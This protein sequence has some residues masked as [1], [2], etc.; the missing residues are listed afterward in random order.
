MSLFKSFFKKKEE[1]PAPEGMPITPEQKALVQETFVSV[2]VISEQAA[3][4]FYNKLFELDPSLKPMFKGDMKEQGRKLMAMLA[5][6]VKGLD[7]L[8]TLVPAVQDLGRRHLTY[9]VEDA[10]YDTVAAALLYTLETGLGKAW[11]PKVQDA[12]TTVYVVLADTMKG[13]AAQAA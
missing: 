7:D 1:E 8:E 12:W 9:G 11:N 3:E 13:A 6:A 5:T 10:H 4:I 2:A